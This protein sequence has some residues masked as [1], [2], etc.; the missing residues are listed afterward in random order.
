MFIEQSQ[1][2]SEVACSALQFTGPCSRSAGKGDRFEYCVRCLVLLLP[3]SKTA[4]IRSPVFSQI[5]FPHTNPN[6]LFMNHI[7]LHSVHRYYN[8]AL[9]NLG[10]RKELIT[11]IKNLCRNLKFSQTTFHLGVAIFDGAL[12]LYRVKEEQHWVL[13]F[14]SVCLA[15]K[16]TESEN[17]LP[18][19]N[20]MVEYF[21]NEYSA[22]DLMFYEVEIVKAFSW[23][24]N[25]RTPFVFA[26]FFFSRG[27]VSS[28]DLQTTQS[29]TSGQLLAEKLESR[30]L[31]L[32]E[33]SLGNYS[34]YYYTSIAV[35]AA[36]VAAA[37]KQFGLVPWPTH[38]EY[39]TFIPWEKI[40][41]CVSGLL[42]EFQETVKT[43][44]KCM[45]PAKSAKPDETRML[46]EQEK[47][48]GNQS[49]PATVSTV[50]SQTENDNKQN[51]KNSKRKSRKSQE[52]ELKPPKDTDFGKVSSV[53]DRQTEPK[54]VQELSEVQKSQ[55]DSVK[56]PKK[57]TL[58][59]ELKP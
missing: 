49:T 48:P 41:N 12:S 30:V 23:N 8:K 31:K 18:L 47:T 51:S 21:R 5:D 55:T 16:T 50:T 27:I 44:K 1:C 19:R 4:M 46:I 11:W 56:D 7:R 22:E 3:E 42:K 54:S 9:L 34:F 26:N 36:A 29:L 40:I 52:E 15:A 37:R 38:M 28:D 17:S 32:L 45:T 57:R 39:L 35:A 20:E 10:H 2:A 6:D 24:L 58:G 59:S 33:V 43:K 14:L 13:A 53:S 25:I